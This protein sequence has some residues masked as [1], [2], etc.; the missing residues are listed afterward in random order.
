VDPK[1]KVSEAGLKKKLLTT[2][3]ERE[4]I[5]DDQLWF[6]QIRGISPIE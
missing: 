6:F 2:C 1:F 5:D 3:M 4:P